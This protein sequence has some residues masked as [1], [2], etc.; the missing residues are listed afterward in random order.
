MFDAASWPT[1]EPPRRG[2]R[3]AIGTVILASLAFF[4]SA[5]PT[6]GKTVIASPSQLRQIEVFTNPFSNKITVYLAN[7]G[8][9]DLHK[10]RLLAVITGAD[11]WRINWQSDN[12]ATIQ[13][14]PMTANIQ[15]FSPP[16]IQFTVN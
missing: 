4:A 11:G 1:P 8:F 14:T 5:M 12:A 9:R 13:T 2:A 10:H 7:A 6:P 3:Y 15:K 16:G